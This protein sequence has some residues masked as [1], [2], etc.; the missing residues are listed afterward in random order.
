MIAVPGQLH[1]SFRLAI[2]EEHPDVAMNMNNLAE[3]YRSQERYSEAELLYNGALKILVTR[4]GE[5]HPNS[6]IV[7]KNYQ[8]FLQ[9][10]GN[11]R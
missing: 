11:D 5:E 1:N 9:Q 2:G 4:L 6:Q 7:Q 3:L 10:V 8:N